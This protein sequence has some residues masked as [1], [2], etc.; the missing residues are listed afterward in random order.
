MADYD[1]GFRGGRVFVGRDL[2]EVDLYTE[3]ES[4]ALLSRRGE[5]Q[6]A[7]RAIDVTGKI[8]LPG[9]IDLHAH[10]RDPGYRLWSFRL[11][12]RSRRDSQSGGRRGYGF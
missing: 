12:C 1:V 3:G 2:L 10:T 11:R 9:I 4:I 5:R 7:K 6:N 8:I